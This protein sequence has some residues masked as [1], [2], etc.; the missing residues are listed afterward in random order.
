MSLAA[1]CCVYP[2]PHYD[3]SP[4]VSHSPKQMSKSHRSLS[5]HSCSACDSDFPTQQ[6]LREHARVSRSSEACQAAVE[7]EFES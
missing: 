3:L 2:G 1:P 7:Y 4:Q 5:F 6:S